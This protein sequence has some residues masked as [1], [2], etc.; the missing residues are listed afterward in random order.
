MEH[1][2][3]LYKKPQ[4]WKLGR[5]WDISIERNLLGWYLQKDRVN[6]IR[7]PYSDHSISCL[8]KTHPHGYLE[9]YRNVFFQVITSHPSPE[10]LTVLLAGSCAVSD[11]SGRLASTSKGL[12][13]AR[14]LLGGKYRVSY[15]LTTPTRKGQR[16]SKSF[17]SKWTGLR[18]TVHLITQ[19]MTCLIK[20]PDFLLLL[21]ETTA[22]NFSFLN[23]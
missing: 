4:G 12:W 7:I 17:G 10:S 11:L 9:K 19:L 8:L 16:S 13:C 5:T 14:R 21:S 23:F 22:C 15:P 1:C 20:K 2:P 18:K 6:Y 3:T